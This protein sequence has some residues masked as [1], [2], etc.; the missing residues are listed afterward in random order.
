MEP[1]AIAKAQ[2]ARKE[3][4]AI[5]NSTEQ[6]LQDAGIVPVEDEARLH[7][8]LN[9]NQ[10]HEFGPQMMTLLFEARLEVARRANAAPEL[11]AKLQQSL[12]AAQIMATEVINLLTSTMDKMRQ[13]SEPLTHQEALWMRKYVHPNMSAEM[14][15]MLDFLSPPGLEGGFDP[16][17]GDLPPGAAAE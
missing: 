8:S 5:L 1:E 7:L 2:A 4:F 16:F 13:S 6:A 15:A 17:N 10:L 3:A 9:K 14:Q 11:L 12:E